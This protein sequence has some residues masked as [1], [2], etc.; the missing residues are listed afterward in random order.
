MNRLQGRRHVGLVRNDVG[1]EDAAS[2]YNR[3][4]DAYVRYADGDPRHLFSF[5]GH[6][7]YA[8]RLV[9][10][11]LET[12]LR[13]LRAT[14]ATSVTILDAGCGPGTWLRRLVTRAHLLGF[15]CTTARGFDVAEVQVL[16]ARRNSQDL[17]EVPG[18]N[19]RFDVADLEDRLPEVDD[20]VDI[21]ICLYSV[22]S[23]LPV[24]RLPQIATEIARVTKGSFV[25]TVR[26]VGSTPTVFVDSMETARDFELD[27]HLDRCEIEFRD[28]RRV[29]LRFHLFTADELMRYFAGR[30]EIEDLRGVDIF[31][32]RFSADYRWNPAS[33]AFDSRFSNL[34]SVLEERYARNPGFMERATHL[35]LVGRRRQRV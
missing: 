3:A 17:N 5:E 15:S 23:H 33:C 16:T 30:F 26:S 6:H 35:M 24:I 34:L 1:V 22:L 19:L 32:G 21:A 2:A 31:H 29:A 4:A 18:V 11:V 14:G 12:K 27:H 28:G 25:T 9:W 13:D 20:S 7:A 8:D 10:S